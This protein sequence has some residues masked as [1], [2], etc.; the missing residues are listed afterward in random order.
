MRTQ[1]YFVIAIFGLI[2]ISLSFAQSNKMQKKKM[3]NDSSKGEMMMEENDKKMMIDFY[4]EDG[5][6][7]E[8]YDPV[9][10]FDMGKPIIGSLKHSYNW[11]GV[12]WYF[13]SSEH[14]MMFKN[15]PEKYAPQYGGY[16][17]YAASKGYVAS[18]DPEA[19]TIYNGKLYLNHSESVNM[20]FHENMEQKIMEADM[21]WK[22]GKL[23]DEM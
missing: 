23:K 13:T 7:I 16:C 3:M 5:V 14:M 9:S 4:N 6:A 11:M 2:I 19:W 21:N 22:E 12:D 18:V 17:A 10:Y 15:N 1:K 20:K 8:G